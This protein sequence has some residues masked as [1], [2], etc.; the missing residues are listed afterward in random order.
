MAHKPSFSVTAFV[1]AMLALGSILS[2]FFLPR[3]PADPE[4][5][6]ASER[7]EFL[8]QAS[9]EQID[10]RTLNEDTFAEARKKD[11]PIMLV[12]G[13]ACSPTGRVGDKFT[14]TSKEIRGYL[15][16]N[17]ICA[18][19]DSMAQPE[20]AAAY[21]P[22][23]RALDGSRGRLPILP[24]FQIWFLDPKGYMFDY[25]TASIQGQS[26][27]AKSLLSDLVAA[28][29][30][31][32]RIEDGQANSG[33]DQRRDLAAI[34][35][36]VG[37]Q[38]PDL[39]QFASYLSKSTP[40]GVGGFPING[41]QRLWPSAWEF[42]LIAG[43]FSDFAHSI[44][45]VLGS[46]QVDLLDGGFFTDGSQL[47]W[48][49]IGY[50]KL[51]TT[52]SAMMQTLA[53]GSV[54]MSDASQKW[55]ALQTYDMLLTQFPQDG[56]IAAGSQG[57][58]SLIGRSVRHSFSPRTLRE[59]FPNNDDREWLRANFRLLVEEN[60]QMT[61]ML[62]RLDLATFD[63]KHF[64]SAIETLKKDRPDQ[65]FV[66]LAQLDVGGFTTARMMRAA[67]ILGDKDRL[68]K[69]EG[70]YERL[71]EFRTFDDVIH[72]HAIGAHPGVYLGDYLAY[73]DGA[74]QYFLATGDPEVFKNG[75]AVLRRGLFLFGGK[76][77]G[78]YSLVQPSSSPLAPQEVDSPE[79][80][81]GSHESCS[82][83]IIRLCNDY[84][85]VLGHNGADL[86]RIAGDTLLRFAGPSSGLGPFVG[87]YFSAAADV[88]DGIYA[89]V[90]GANRVS[91]ANRLAHLAPTRLVAPSLPT[92][93]PTLLPGVYVI[94]DTST[95][96]PMTVEK[97]AELLKRPPL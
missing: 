9:H 80:A 82:A 10:W 77:K 7:S 8:L 68:L 27:D 66:G 47:D 46:P 32:G 93:G 18:R 76:V 96:G 61:P 4:N 64:S 85:R 74:F 29:R 90:F 43:R 37:E 91:D 21:L 71:D 6:L 60:P 26:L 87:G 12:V 25:G 17:F 59:L 53:L 38:F 16:R 41:T 45:P 54:L 31:Y 65:R 83:Q 73:A 57:D 52:N 35:A 51:A 39:P 2:R 1:I 95:Q 14:F 15:A 48:R 58:E 30:I 34:R 28:V 42:Q 84:G 22:L 44:G 19:V 23:T 11:K 20:F 24:N 94:S 72:S 79:I 55:M 81:D 56:L 13:D 3:I 40:S 97:A 49:S 33:E 70:L 88:Q 69:A 75:V 62:K 5:R 89:Q 86:R 63:A 67:R 50:D 92:N 36:P 78:V